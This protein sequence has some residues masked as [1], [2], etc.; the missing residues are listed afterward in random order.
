MC[1]INCKIFPKGITVDTVL[2]VYAKV[3]DTQKKFLRDYVL[4]GC[5]GASDRTIVRRV[6]KFIHWGGVRCL[7]QVDGDAIVL[8]RVGTTQ[9]CTIT[10][11][12]Y[13]RPA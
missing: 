2:L 4:S 12:T 7:T 1:W 11:H 13:G 6:R 10:W 3:E 5:E 8:H 9:K